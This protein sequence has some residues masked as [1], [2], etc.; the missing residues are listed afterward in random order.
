M[1][2]LLSCGRG[3]FNSG[4]RAAISAIPGV[5]ELC[6]LAP[7]LKRD[8]ASLGIAAIGRLP[9]RLRYSL[10]VIQVL[11]AKFRAVSAD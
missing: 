6:D 7:P 10:P 3:C 2:L 1:I 4:E 9:L 5:A 11:L 8:L